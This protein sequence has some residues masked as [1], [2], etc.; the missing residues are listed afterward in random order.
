MYSH[1]QNGESHMNFLRVARTVTAL[2]VGLLPTSGVLAQH[3]ETKV[4]DAKVVYV[5]GNDVIV[6]L[7]GG[8]VKHF[9]I[10]DDSRFTINGKD[11]NVHELK[12]GMMLTAR[13]TTAVPPRWVDSV[14][15]VDIGTVWKTIGSNLIIT[16]PEG[17]NMMLR[18]PAGGKITINGQVKT[19][20]QLR[21]GDKITA[22]VVKTRAPAGV[23]GTASLMYH[24]PATPARVGVLL[25][26][27]GAKPPEAARNW[28]IP[29]LVLLIIVI[30]V[31]T[32]FML[33]TYRRRRKAQLRKPAVAR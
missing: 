32:V 9:E 12:S 33:F 10:P 13:I 16:T 24:A 4:E 18:V 11:V 7:S 21:E 8:E 30:M 1:E 3:V 28:I 5:E 2:L 22:T 17:E 6:K 23:G 29:S 19:L 26:D 31:V 14:S 27:E 20:D 25:I 15:I